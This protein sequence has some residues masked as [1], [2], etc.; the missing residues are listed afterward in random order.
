VNEGG[1][2]A[3]RDAG[4][5]KRALHAFA[6]AQDRVVMGGERLGS[7]TGRFVAD[8][9]NRIGEGTADIDGEPGP[10]IGCHGVAGSGAATP[11]RPCIAELSMGLARDSQ[12][13]SSGGG[14]SSEAGRQTTRSHPVAR[15]PIRR[16]KTLS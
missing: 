13:E 3:E 15:R 6:G 9:E 10:R 8:G 11:E 4:A 7:G 1:H 16:S 14:Q 2:I 5:A 12:L